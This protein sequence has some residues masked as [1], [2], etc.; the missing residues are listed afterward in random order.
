M[1]PMSNFSDVGRLLLIAGG[2]LIVLG[3]VFLLVGRV[4]LIGRLPCD[5]SFRRGNV[6]VYFPL[7]TCILASVVITVLLNVVLWLFRR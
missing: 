4:P 7:V 2:I 3:I 6:Q 5:I 1:P